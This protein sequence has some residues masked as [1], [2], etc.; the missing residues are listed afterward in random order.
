MRVGPKPEIPRVMS[1]QKAKGYLLPTAHI[2][3]SNVKREWR[4]HL[5]PY[6]RVVS[7]YDGEEDEGRAIS[8]CIKKLWI[9]YLESHGLPSSKCPFE[10]LVAT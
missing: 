6:C 5:P 2:W 10:E 9:Q 7:P 1:Q 8:L 3:V 4:G